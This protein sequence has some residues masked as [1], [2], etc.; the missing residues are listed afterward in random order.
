[1][2]C[3]LFES[4]KFEKSFKTEKNLT[5][6][7]S[8]FNFSVPSSQNKNVLSGGCSM[9]GICASTNTPH[10]CKDCAWILLLMEEA[11]LLTKW[12]NFKVWLH[13]WSD[14]VH[15]WLRLHSIHL[16]SDKVW[17]ISLLNWLNKHREGVPQWKKVSLPC[18]RYKFDYF[19]ETASKVQTTQMT[20]NGFL[21]LL[22]TVRSGKLGFGFGNDPVWICVGLEFESFWAS[23]H[24]LQ[25]F[26]QQK[27]CPTNCQ[28][29]VEILKESNVCGHFVWVSVVRFPWWGMSVWCGLQCSRGSV[30][31]LCLKVA[32]S[33]W[34]LHS[35]H[36]VWIAPTADEFGNFAHW[37]KKRR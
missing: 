15:L 10:N 8:F 23:V 6:C 2:C 13:I 17:S 28:E 37:N 19:L 7:K 30:V 36:L 34:L 20:E 18:A 35:G 32:T 1:M 22:V 24:Q 26:L 33:H 25:H 5:S 29:R 27:L 14:K 9:G 16:S 11:C 31:K 12:R 3:L 4:L 21:L